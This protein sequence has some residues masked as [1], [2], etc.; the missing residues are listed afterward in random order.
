[1]SFSILL[2]TLR[3]LL[4]TTLHFF[5]VI[6]YLKF[7]LSFWIEYILILGKETFNANSYMLKF[8]VLINYGLQIN[9]LL[10]TRLS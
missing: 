4:V 1:M 9:M 3:P 7:T 2:A 6:D 10:M 8:N 5:I